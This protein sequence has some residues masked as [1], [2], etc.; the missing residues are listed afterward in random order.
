MRAETLRAFGEWLAGTSFSLA[1]QSALWVIPLVQTVHILA[2]AALMGAAI[3]INLRLFGILGRDE[4]IAAVAHRF[5][6]LVW[7]AL[8]VLLFSGS[9]L[10]IGEPGRSV[11]NPAMHAKLLMI[12]TVAL[13]TL[14]IT[15]PLARDAAC[16]ERSGARCAC[17]RALAAFSLLLWVA[18]IFAGR[19]IAYL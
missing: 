3:N 17:A 11:E 19:W 8:L 9:L 10:I 1:I 13:L 2:I 12:V 14:S 6:P 5:E 4:P 15:R 16:W 18:I 7:C